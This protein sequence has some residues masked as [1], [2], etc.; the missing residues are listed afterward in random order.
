M[1]L[2]KQEI[3]QITEARREAIKEKDV[4]IGT[5]KTQRRKKD[6]QINELQKEIDSIKRINSSYKND[7]SNYINENNALGKKNICLNDENNYLKHENDTLKE[8][9]TN[10]KEM[11]SNLTAMNITLKE[12]NDRSEVT[13]LKMISQ[14]KELKKENGDLRRRRKI[15]KEIKKFI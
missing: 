7:V 2:S 10:L 9:N 15:P 3:I 5:L 13:Q 6:D 1:K 11:N 12:E 14:T 8:D 4:T